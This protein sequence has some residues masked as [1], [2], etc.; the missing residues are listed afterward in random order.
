MGKSRNGRRSVERLTAVC[1][2]P[3][4]FFPKERGNICCGASTLALL[5][6]TPPERIAKEHNRW[7]KHYPDWLMLKFLRQHGFSVYNITT[8]WV[9]NGGRISMRHVVLISQLLRKGEGTWGVM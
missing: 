2:D 9:I 5:T 8:D 7:R 6:G 1:F 3:R 4:L